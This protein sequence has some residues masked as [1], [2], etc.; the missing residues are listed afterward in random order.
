MS[1]QSRRI[2]P[3]IV[4]PVIIGLVGFFSLTQRPRFQTFHTVDVLQ[5]LATGMCFG[6][7]LAVLIATLR[8]KR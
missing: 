6:I 1:D 2:L 3:A 4:L 7:A 8:G 5:L